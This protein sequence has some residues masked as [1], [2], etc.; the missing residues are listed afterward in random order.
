MQLSLL[1][2]QIK[3]RVRSRSRKACPGE[4]DRR[5]HQIPNTAMIVRSAIAL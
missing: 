2:H 1:T 3:P 4:L 5:S